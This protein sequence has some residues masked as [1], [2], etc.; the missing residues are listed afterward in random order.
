MAADVHLGS[1]HLKSLLVSC[2]QYSIK[3]YCCC[4]AGVAN[5]RDL[6]VV[7]VVYPEW[8][9]EFAFSFLAFQQLVLHL[10]AATLSR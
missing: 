6:F 7:V 2:H 1:S 3:D 8:S 5:D 4:S 9:T 10:C